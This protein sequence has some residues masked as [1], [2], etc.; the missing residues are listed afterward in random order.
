MP[1]TVQI[2][3]DK[4]ILK[5]FVEFHLQF[6][7]FSIIFMCYKKIKLRFPK[8]NS[9]ITFLLHNEEFQINNFH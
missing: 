9:Y 3:S 6:Q 2:K 7:E 8:G 1:R 5:Y 4:T